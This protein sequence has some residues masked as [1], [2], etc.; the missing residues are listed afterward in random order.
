M[1]K[2]LGEAEKLLKTGNS[3]SEDLLKV[4][5]LHFIELVA[6]FKIALHNKTIHLALQT[7]KH[8]ISR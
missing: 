5:Q 2:P 1:L 3:I 7:C 4:K 6:D 8:Y